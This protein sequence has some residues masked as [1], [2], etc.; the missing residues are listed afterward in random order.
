MQA[1]AESVQ[2]SM[3]EGH[4]ASCCLSAARSASSPT[5]VR[6]RLR[7]ELDKAEPD[8]GPPLRAPPAHSDGDL[9]LDESSA[10][11]GAS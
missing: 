8:R 1:V 10:N 7:S 5:A 4:S 9:E 11:A 2:G 6:T 3:S